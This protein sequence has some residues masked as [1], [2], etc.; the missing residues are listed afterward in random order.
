MRCFSGAHVSIAA[1][2]YG[3][4][5]RGL[6]RRSLRSLL[7]KTFK[8]GVYAFPRGPEREPPKLQKSLDV[9]Q[10]RLY[11]VKTRGGVVCSRSV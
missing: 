8:A 11:Y 3:Q 9:T 1:G 5:D 10:L 7:A 6:P 2:D 4:E